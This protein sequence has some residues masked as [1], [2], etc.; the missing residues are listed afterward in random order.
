MYAGRFEEMQPHLELAATLLDRTSPDSQ[1]AT[2]LSIQLLST[3]VARARGDIPALVAAASEALDALPGP[4]VL[5]PTA[6]Q[7]RAIALA[8]LGSG[9]LWSGDFGRAETT[10]LKGLDVATSSGLDAPQITMLAHLGLAAALLG[11]LREAFAYATKAVELV[12]VRGWAPLAQASAAYLALAVVHLAWND[13][14]EA[15]RLLGLGRAAVHDRAS[16]F[17]VDLAHVWLDASAGR[18]AAALGQ[19]LR[20]REEIRYWQPP[21]LLARWLVVTEAEVMLAA[22]DYGGAATRIG[23]PPDRRPPYAFERVSIARARLA[24]GDLQQAE[25]ILAELRGGVVERVAVV[26][27]WVLS[28]LVADRLREDSRAVDALARAVRAAAPDSIRGPFLA[29][30]NG[31]LPRLLT[32]LRQLDPSSEEFV[33]ELLADLGVDRLKGGETDDISEPLTDR[34]LSVLRY[35]PTMMTNAEI[36]A[37]LSVSVN[38]IKAHLKRIYRKLG[39]ISRREAVHRARELRLL[40]GDPA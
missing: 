21:A 34:E 10:L 24:R 4:D 40:S 12:D 3:V 25:A 13:V 23:T 35:L 19:V 11:R 8:S 30:G 32:R 31:R 7:Y 17:A 15:R 28:A 22:K 36:A 6:D 16:A 2:V 33:D 14:D 29:L 37:E 18:V 39:V 5:L 38:T 9:L 1:I 20:L 27:V 26:E